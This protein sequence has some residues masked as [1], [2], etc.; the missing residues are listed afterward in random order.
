MNNCTQEELQLLILL[1]ES[2]YVDDCV[3]SFSDHREMEAFRELSTRIM[4]KAG[5]D[6][7]K[8]G[9]N[10]LYPGNDVSQRGPVLGVIWDTTSYTLFMCLHAGDVEDDA[11][12]TRRRLLRVVA[13]LFDPLGLVAPLHITGKILLQH[14][15]REKTDWD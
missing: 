13:S 15:W 2:F 12:W 1:R 3:S 7:R 6:L 9:S 8:W 11:P 5:M 14:A 4:A 10:A